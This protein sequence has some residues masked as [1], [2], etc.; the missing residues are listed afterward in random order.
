MGEVSQM[1]LAGIR[2][3]DLS[4]IYNGPYATYLLALAGAEV[5]KIEPPAGEPLRK[6]AVV[7]GAGLPFAMLNGAK[8]SITLDL[9]SEDGK[10][11]LKALAVD[12]DILVENFSPGVMDRLG[13]GADVLAQINPRLIYAAS[14]GYGRDG[15]YAAYP[16]MDLTMQAMSGALYVT[17]FPEREPVKCGPA[18]ADFFAGIHLH[19]AIMT[20]LFERER[21]GIARRVEVTMQDAIYA[22]LSSNLGLAW[23]SNGDD[24]APAR[25]ANRHGGL[26]EC[27]YNV[28]PT[29]N[30][31]IAMICA[32][33]E[34]WQRLAALMGKAELG[35]DPRYA[36]LR[37]RVSRM[38][39][40]DAM[41]GEWSSQMETQ[42]CFDLLMG[43]RIACA[44]V[45]TLPE[46]MEDENMIARGSL[47]DVDHPR[48]GQ[49]KVQQ[50]PLRL[51]G[52]PLRAPSPSEDL[53]ASTREILSALAG[54]DEARITAASGAP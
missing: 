4:Q 34:H 54:F 1:P 13:L 14:S 53:G 49:I 38:E 6:R 47:I 50:T 44:P 8:R 3:I 37:E 30:G 36:T 5:I 21:T 12:A 52:S 46:V 16:A 25:T 24:A 7:G 42:A 51:E 31:H 15:P 17:G 23:A 18:V 19:A 32:R 27:P 22:S 28:Y 39:E 35:F 9:K 10:A 2:V 41:I 48:Y 43:A 29:A 40:V 33:D 11:A 26:A 20:A 45:R